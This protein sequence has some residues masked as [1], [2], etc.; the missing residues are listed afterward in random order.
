MSVYVATSKGLVAVEEELVLEEARR[1]VRRGEV[2]YAWY[3]LGKEGVLH[4]KA[5]GH[6]PGAKGYYIVVEKI[7]P[8]CDHY[9]EDR[10][11]RD[12]LL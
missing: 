1:W 4:L 5:A 10:E 11:V 8:R 7:I 12:N 3:V 2:D 6:D 9:D